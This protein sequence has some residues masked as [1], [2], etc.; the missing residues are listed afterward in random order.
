MWLRSDRVTMAGPT[1][2][3]ASSA[4]LTA[5]NGKRQVVTPEAVDRLAGDDRASTWI[6]LQALADECMALAVA[7]V[8]ETVEESVALAVLVPTSRRAPAAVPRSAA[9]SDDAVAARLASAS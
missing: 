7:R 9:P 5:L 2:E 1:R 8:V 3:E 6:D 4:L